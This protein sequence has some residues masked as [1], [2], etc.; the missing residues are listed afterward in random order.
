[1]NQDLATQV[2]TAALHEAARQH[3]TIAVSI[4]DTGGHLQA[5]MRMDNCSF[6]AVDASR[7]KAVSACAFGMPTD[8]IG[9]AVQRTPFLKEAFQGHPD[10]FYFGG[11]LPVFQQGKIIGGLGVSGVEPAQDKTIASKALASVGLMG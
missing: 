6:V 5:F 11:G 10:I 3:V 9:E 7:K 8:A 4:V 1:M 2:L